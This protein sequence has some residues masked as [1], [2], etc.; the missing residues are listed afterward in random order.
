MKELKE[1]WC[2]ETDNLKKIIISSLNG[3]FKFI[4]DK[5]LLGKSDKNSDEFDNLLFVRRDIEEFSILSN[6]KIISSCAFQ[7]CQKLTK[8]EISKQLGQMHL[9]IQISEK[10]LFHQKF[11]KYVK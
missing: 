7:Y 1:E 10:F 3:Q 2:S 5:Y 4:D 9:I 8:V 11:Q 6:I